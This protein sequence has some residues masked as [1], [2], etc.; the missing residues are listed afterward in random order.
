MKECALA[1][2]DAREPVQVEVLY[3]VCVSPRETGV[4]GTRDWEA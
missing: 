3:A 4:N 2:E 1:L